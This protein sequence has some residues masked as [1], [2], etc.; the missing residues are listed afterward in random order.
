MITNSL[1]DAGPC[2]R[3]IR[4]RLSN[5]TGAS[6]K[7]TWSIPGW[8]TKCENKIKGYNITYGTIGGLLKSTFVKVEDKNQTKIEHPLNNLI[9]ETQYL[10][11]ITVNYANDS[12]ATFKRPIYQT[13]GRGMLT[14]GCYVTVYM[15]ACK[16]DFKCILLLLGI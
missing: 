16:V 7:L 4:L 2:G 13:S 14:D 1:I 10:I 3:L 5:E 15:H 11:V 12:I 6:I 9:P 8:N